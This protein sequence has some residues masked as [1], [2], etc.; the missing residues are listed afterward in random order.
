MAAS[1]WTADLPFPTCRGAQGWVSHPWGTDIHPHPEQD[2]E[3]Q[4]SETHRDTA[5]P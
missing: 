4:C 3:G 2:G 5:L 1:G